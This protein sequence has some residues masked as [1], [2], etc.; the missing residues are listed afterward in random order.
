MTA[1]VYRFTASWC[2]PCKALAGLLKRENIVIKEVIDIDESPNAKELTAHYGVR[3]VP[4][5]V[6]DYGNGDFTRIVGSD[7]SPVNKDLL[8][9]WTGSVT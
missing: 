5:I 1:K 3:S 9:K 7:I 4:T 8:K 6:I 2:Q